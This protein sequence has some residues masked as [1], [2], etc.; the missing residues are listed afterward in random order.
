MEIKDI[1]VGFVFPNEF[2]FTNLLTL[3]KLSY[4]TVTAK[5]FIR[6]V[7]G[8]SCYGEYGAPQG[9]KFIT[10]LFRNEIT[11]FFIKSK[12][13][14]IDKMKAYMTVSP[15]KVVLRYKNPR[16][17]DMGRYNKLMVDADV[18]ETNNGF[19]KYLRNLGNNKNINVYP[20]FIR[21][22]NKL[23]VKYIAL[24][25]IPHNEEEEELIKADE[26]VYYMYQQLCLLDNIYNKTQ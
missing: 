26:Y 13:S 24:D 2:S 4:N 21:H 23:N 11:P 20:R 12:D 25:V 17:V 8:G 14:G 1:F 22:K 5:E 10:A 6:F 16:I 3:N 7:D 19:I 15:D 18:V 9:D